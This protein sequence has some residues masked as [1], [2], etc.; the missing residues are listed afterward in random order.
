M[1]KTQTE[2]FHH[3]TSQHDGENS[4]GENTKEVITAADS[5]HN[6]TFMCKHTSLQFDLVLRLSPANRTQDRWSSVVSAAGREPES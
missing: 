4:E 5:E 2:L 1:K 6:M 3:L